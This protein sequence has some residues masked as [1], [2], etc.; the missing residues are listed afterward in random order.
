MG[1]SNRDQRSS[2]S[3]ENRC[4]LPE[5]SWRTFSDSLDNDDD[6]S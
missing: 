5:D 6:M 2:S 4:S 1:E 3:C